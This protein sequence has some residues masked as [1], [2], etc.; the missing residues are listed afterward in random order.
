VRR[1]HD[2]YLIPG[3]FGFAN[4]GKLTYFGH[5]R[6]YL[7]QAAAARGIEARVH[8][9]KTHP[10]ASLAERAARVV[11]K[12]SVTAS[13]GAGPIHLI[14]H[15][16]GGMDARLFA[17]PGVALPT[18]VDTE[19]FAA[20]LA[21]VVSVS[22]PHYGTPL[23]SFFASRLGQQTLQGL[24][25]STIYMLRYGQLPLRGLLQLG[26]MFARWDSGA[27]NSAL[28]DHVFDVV[29]GN[30]SVGRRRAVQKLFSEV[31]KDQALLTQLTPEAVEVFNAAVRD[32]PGVRY[33]SVVTRSVKPGVRSVRETG[34]DPAGQALH[35][36]Y[37]TLHRI[38]S[39]TP[40]R[41][42]PRL[43]AKQERALKRAYRRLPS[44]A[45]N[46]GIVPTRAQVWGEV[47]AAV[48]ADHLDVIGH[49]GDSS[50]RPPHVDWLATGTGCSLERYEKVWSAIVDFLFGREG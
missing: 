46:D 1:V 10:T 20:R 34:L 4:L 14:G 3:F 17:T 40:S 22:T 38:A 33:G 47:V 28:L 50:T 41:A 8:V 12:V 43:T 15:S 35:T 27:L 7:L 25:L 29:L 16:S 45:D 49:F 13:R 39:Q 19:R 26:A 36:V 48:H 24:S 21:T 5:V 6:P 30:F 2:I 44:V 23:A 32:R 42:A 18:D 11:R 9:V 37:A 31:A